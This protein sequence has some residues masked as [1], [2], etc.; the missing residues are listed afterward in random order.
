MSRQ[1]QQAQTNEARPEDEPKASPH[2][3]TKPIVT[4]ET[5]ALDHMGRRK[6]LRNPVEPGPIR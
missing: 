4:V 5:F 1:K 3:D 2:V 6:P